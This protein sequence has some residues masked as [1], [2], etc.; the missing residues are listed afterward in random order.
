MRSIL[1]GILILLSLTAPLQAQ[2]PEALFQIGK[3]QGATIE[4]P[5]LQLFWLTI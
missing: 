5:D 4:L 2:H 3:G 1:F